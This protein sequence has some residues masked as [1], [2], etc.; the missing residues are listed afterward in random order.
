MEPADLHLHR[1]DSTGS[2]P[3]IRRLRRFLSLAVRRIA[4]RLPLRD[5]DRRRIRDFAFERTGFLFSW[6][7]TYRNWQRENE[8][9]A[10]LRRQMSA[11]G[12]TGNRSA[13][14]D[15]APHVELSALPRPARLLARAIAFYLPQFHPIPE[16]DRW[17]GKDF[18][19]W[20]NVRR[21]RAQFEGHRQPRRPGELGYYDLL[22]DPE[23]RRRQAALASQYGLEG[24][25][26]YYYW[27]GGRQL[28]EQPV[29]AYA[30]DKEITFPFC[31]CWANESWSRRWDGREDQLLIAQY[32]SPEDDIA[33]ISNIS[34]YLASDKYLRV[35]G[36]PLVILYRP[37]LLP[38]ARA[39]AR[40]WRDWCRKNGVGE[41][42]LAYTLS[43]AS[44]SPDEYG[45]D[46]A[47]EFP[48]NN[49]GLAPQEGRVTPIGDASGARIHDLSQLPL[50]NTPYRAPDFRLFRGVTPQ[51]D[52]TA[53]RMG[54]ATIMLDDGPGLYEA[55]LRSAAEDMVRRE[56]RPDE[57]LVFINA[58]NE[59]AEGAYLEPDLDH[60]YAWLEATRRALDPSAD[61]MV[62]PRD[63]VP[64][65]PVPAARPAT[66]ILLVVH[67][68]ARNGAQIHSLHL[69][70]VWSRRFGCEV[71]ILACEDGPLRPNFETYGR[72]LIL[73]KDMA[74]TRDFNSALSQL[75]AGGFDRAIINSCA[76][77][78]I[79]PYLDHAGIE[80]LGLV[81]ELPGLIGAMNLAAG[82][83]AFETHARHVV[84]ASD[85]VRKR[86]EEEV[87]ARP[88]S[89]PVI[90]PQGLYKAESIAAP[91]EK[92]I[93]A[94]EIRER[95]SLPED[96]QIV[97][98]VGFGDHR[99]G[100][101]I[102]C[103]WALEAAR[104]D[105]RL[106]FLWIGGLSPGMRAECHAIL[107]NAGALADNVRLLGF[108]ND[109]G[110]FFKA[111]CAYAL[112]SR[113]DP[114]PSTVLEALACGTPAFI[115]SGTTGLASLSPS[116]AIIELEDA[117]PAAFAETLTRL[118]RSAP[119]RKKAAQAG[120]ELIRQSYGFQSFAGDLLRLAGVFQPRISVIVPNY[121]YARYLP[122]RIAS[123][124]NQELPVWEIIFLDDASTDDS[125]EVA[126]GLLKDCGIHYRIVPNAK[127]SG[128]VFA[129]WQKGVSLARGEIVWI[130][131]ADDWAA[132]SF[133][134][135]AAEALRDEAVVLSY[136]QSNQVSRASEI[137][138]PHYLDYVADIDKERWRRSFVNDGARELAEGLS[139]KNTIPNVSGVLFRRG[140]LAA[141]LDQH[142]TEICSYR[143]AGD[144]CVYAHLAGMGKIAFDPR[145]LNYHRRHQES[146]TISR[147]TRAEFDEIARMQ[148]RVGEL[149][150]VAPAMRQKAAGYLAHLERRLASPA[151]ERSDQ[152]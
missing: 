59:W 126:E 93:A 52:N 72:L 33:F 1:P 7:V 80:A 117:D 19:E 149:A 32:H 9:L 78:W 134:Q 77:G 89:R 83:E 151:M 39:T 82:I 31:L 141:T 22:A 44:G 137:L 16:N 70:R 24:F 148:A 87:L 146:V 139:V 47:I 23:V 119:R 124:L 40:R 118:V 12:Q 114:Y 86:T 110:A 64:L 53:R 38:D 76:G 123:I 131:E 10:S 144:W 2:A 4:A 120:I 95:L 71:A 105:T 29:D 28:L 100:P 152:G 142:M 133:T 65:G 25:C 34:R 3:I 129:Q 51:W 14:A 143:V 138:C 18:T 37:D 11:A 45:F 113:E 99:K 61:R 109:T 116:P 98:G 92:E 73:R 74:G 135:V 108:Q 150:E 42:F 132:S 21:A 145:S 56:G 85:F 26:F 15:R 130:A 84:F 115:V 27:F 57:R 5:E 50:G 30:G 102:F 90:E 136:T 46:A 140:A 97:I 103:R 54:H 69:A 81:H 128:S 121:N 94:R 55:W 41:I 112:S 43:F 60:G 147:F 62:E 96:A 125:L 68:L 106:H 63:L 17:W 122:H 48:P 88:W 67:D 79:T 111:A 104:L 8:H 35:G 66:R 107:A 36:R 6:T 127:N 20:T 75:K 13:A 58:W 101:D 49:M 91:A